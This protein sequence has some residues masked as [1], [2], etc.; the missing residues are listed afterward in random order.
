MSFN[1]KDDAVAAM[2]ADARREFEKE[3]KATE[4]EAIRKERPKSVT[5][6]RTE[7]ETVIGSDTVRTMLADALTAAV[8]RLETIQE[9]HPEIAL[10]CDLRIYRDA[11]AW[12]DRIPTNAARE[13]AFRHD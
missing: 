9:T 8:K 2:W 11:L 1:H 5:K 10:D 7:T 13:K 12:H 6:H 4:F 3:E